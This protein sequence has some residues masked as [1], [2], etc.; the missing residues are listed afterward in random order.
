MDRRMFRIFRNSSAQRPPFTRRFFPAPA[1]VGA[2]NFAA[3][4]ILRSDPRWH[5]TLPDEGTDNDDDDEQAPADPA[6]G[7]GNVVNPS[8]QNGVGKVSV[9]SRHFWPPQKTTQ[10]RWASARATSGRH[11]LTHTQPG[12]GTGRFLPLP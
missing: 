7:G 9:P 5:R 3:T 12:T 1:E 2:A 4:V 6:S 10:I 8:V 11:T